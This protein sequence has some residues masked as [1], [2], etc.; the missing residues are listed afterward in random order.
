MH[1]DIAE[2]ALPLTLAPTAQA[3]GGAGAQHLR[4][5]ASLRQFLSGSALVTLMD[6][7]WSVL[8]IT[9]LF[10]I[11]GALGALVLAGAAALLA[12]A[13][14]N[15]AMMRKPLQHATVRQMQ[16][17]REL[18]F[19]TRNADVIAAMGMAGALAVRWKA[20]QAGVNASQAQA[21]SRGAV[22]QGV[23]KFAR[24][25]LQVLV[26]GAAAWLAIEGAVTIGAIIAASILASRALAPFEAAIGSWKSLSESR[27]AFRRLE[28]ALQVAPR[29]EAIKLPIPQGALSV[30]NVS[31][32][33]PGRPAILRGVSFRLEPG[34]AL[35]VIGPS[36]SGKSTLARLMM[37]VWQPVGGIIRLD[38]ADVYRWI[39][40]EFGR[41]AG[42]LPQDV[43]LFGGSVKENIARFQPDAP[44][45]AVVQA[46]Q[47]AGAHELILRLPN[48]YETEIGAG[49]AF[50]SAGQRQ[51]IG[52]AR[53]FFGMPK[54]LVL[55][56]P[57]SNLDEAG[58]QALLLALKH[59]KL[60]RI[61]T[62]VMT[63]RKSILAHVDKLLLLKNGV[64]E[65]FG[66]RQQVTASL[67]APRRGSVEGGR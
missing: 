59:A 38:E 16:A 29:E 39:R 33:V 8:Y 53:A 61:T 65:A 35:G 46:A 48:G 36:G 52:L 19:A 63:H 30:E 9:V 64:V 60:K 47:L 20:L 5:A 66:P 62:V 11:H 21:S 55:D 25:S 18:E 10:I 32:A 50:L 56:E 15:E 1:D 67:A 27:L 45:E 58:K 26:T 49:G 40:E 3:D 44:P 14:L 34:E 28:K 13:W 51:R 37:G 12:L 54:F 24:L 23:T 2:A 41:F 6:A 22:I 7:P 43:E 4:D 17:M 42:Y 57:D 31:Y